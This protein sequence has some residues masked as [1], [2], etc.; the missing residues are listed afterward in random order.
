[1]HTVTTRFNA[2]LQLT[3]DASE[4]LMRFARGELTWAEVEGITFQQAMQM[5]RTGCELAARGRLDEARI[6]FE[7]LVAMNPKDTSS[8][9]ALGN[10]YQK[11]GRIDDALASY[12]RAIALF[13]RN[14][15]ALASR[16]EIRLRRGDRAGYTDLLRAAEL[17][18]KGSTAAG[19]RALALVEAAAAAAK[20]ERR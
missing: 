14:V 2:T 11:L 18:P 12:D 5:A 6:I 20:K 7:G 15:V 19:R 16:G 17:D 8:H 1:M 4:R 9:A 13:D 10:V 3:P